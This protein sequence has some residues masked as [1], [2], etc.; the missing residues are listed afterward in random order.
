VR[1]EIIFSDSESIQ[2]IKEKLPHLFQIA[3]L[4]SSRDGKI[5]MEVGSLREKIIIAMLINFYGIDNVRTDIPIT[6]SEVD[7]IVDDSPISIKTITG[8]RI[9]GVKVIWTVDREK[10]NQFVENYGPD[11]DM[12]FVHINWDDLGG[13]YF[14]PVDVQREVLENLSVERYLKIPPV[15]TNPRGVEISNEVMRILTNHRDTKKIIIDWKKSHIAF[16]P[17]KRWLDHWNS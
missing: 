7:V 5:G 10:I 12:L 1:P 16:N 3:E 9:I 2:K 15:G 8:R 17:Y 4:E 6:E 13:L 11:C 14:I